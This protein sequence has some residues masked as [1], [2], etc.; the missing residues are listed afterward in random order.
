M[1]IYYVSVD[2]MTLTFQ[3]KVEQE[4]SEAKQNLKDAQENKTA[5]EGDIQ[6][7]KDTAEQMREEHSK[8]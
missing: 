4:L 3:A 1:T 7:L 8:V 5:L 2:L 6:K